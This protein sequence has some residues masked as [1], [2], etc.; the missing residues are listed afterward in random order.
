MVRPYELV[1]SDRNEDDDFLVN[2]NHVGR[3]NIN[4]EDEEEEEDSEESD[5]D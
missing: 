4:D 3:L 1:D 5:S 2:A